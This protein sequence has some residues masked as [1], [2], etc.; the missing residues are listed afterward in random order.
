MSKHTPGPWRYSNN[1][2]TKVL[3]ADGFPVADVEETAITDWS[4]MGIIHWSDAPGRAYIERSE[5]E[6]AANG[7]LLAAAPDLYEALERLVYC[8]SNDMDV[9]PST[10][11]QARA[12]LAKVDRR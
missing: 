4:D 11:A 3:G 5:E 1:Y 6:Q 2:R 12:A 7:L 9:G 10:L 8:L